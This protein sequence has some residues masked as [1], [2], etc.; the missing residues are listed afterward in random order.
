[1]EL[2]GFVPLLSLPRDEDEE[3]VFCDDNDDR[4]ILLAMTEEEIEKVK[5]LKRLDKLCLF[6][7]Y[8]CGMEEALMRFDVAN[9]RYKEIKKRLEIE[10]K[11]TENLKTRPETGMNEELKNEDKLFFEQKFND[12]LFLDED[13]IQLKGYYF[14]FLIIFLII[15]L[16]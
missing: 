15:F 4:E 5:D 8:L 3:L 7:E 2:A 13:L 11:V 1:L 6:G 12:E 16:V 9:E 10:D 14:I